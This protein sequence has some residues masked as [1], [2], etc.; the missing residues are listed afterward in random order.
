M[1][2]SECQGWQRTRKLPDILCS[3]TAA[4]DERRHKTAD[5]PVPHVLRSFF[6]RRQASLPPI[7]KVQTSERI[8]SRF[9]VR[10]GLSAADPNDVMDTVIRRYDCP[11]NLGYTDG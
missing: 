5:H 7:V 10:G 1:A 2:R 9:D 6:T 8:E 3:S 4:R 11:S